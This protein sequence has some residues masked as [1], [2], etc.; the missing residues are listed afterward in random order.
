MVIVIAYYGYVH[1]MV[2]YLVVPLGSI[3]F[4]WGGGPSTVVITDCLRSFYHYKQSIF[5]R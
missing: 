3:A 1:T 4:L 2:G 5:E